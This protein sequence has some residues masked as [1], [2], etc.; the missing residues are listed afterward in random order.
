M[1]L[2]LFS[3]PFLLNSFRN[4]ARSQLPEYETNNEAAYASSVR[5]F[6]SQ[7]LN[8]A[9]QKNPELPAYVE[10]LIYRVAQYGC[11]GEYEYKVS[12]PL[13]Y[14]D[15]IAS[16]LRIVS[17]RRVWPD[18]ND[19]LGNGGNYVFIICRSTEELP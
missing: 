14:C 2:K 1:G 19:S 12:L 3:N 13:L 9:K 17:Q 5:Q 16:G 11:D 4:G 15:L 10:N 18:E 8:T 6:Y 7:V